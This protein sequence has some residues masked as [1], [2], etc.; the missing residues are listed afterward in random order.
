MPVKYPNNSVAWCTEYPATSKR[1]GTIIRSRFDTTGNMIDAAE[2][3]SDNV[4]M[5]FMIESVD[6][7][8]DCSVG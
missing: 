3:G 1:C 5:R 4:K 6:S 2:T 7:F 8:F